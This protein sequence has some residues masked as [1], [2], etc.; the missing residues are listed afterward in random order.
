MAKTLLQLMGGSACKQDAVV[1]GLTIDSRGVREG[2][3]F[4]AVPGAKLDGRAYIGEALRKGAAAILTVPGGADDVAERNGQPIIEH[5]NPRKLYAEMAAKFYGQQPDVQVAVTGTNGKTSVADFTRQIWQAIGSEAASYGTLGV[6]S[7][8]LTVEGGLTTPDPMALHSTLANL[9][10]AGIDHVAVEASSHGLDQCRLDGMK[11]RAAA[12]TNLTRDHLDYHGT[13]QAYFQA[14]ARLFIDLVDSESGCVVLNVDDPWGQILDDIAV[15]LR[16]NRISYG[17][18]KTAALRLVS[19]KLTPAGQDVEITYDGAEIAFHIPLLGEFQAFNVLAAMG[20]AIA[21]GG[22]IDDVV[23]AIPKL[24]GVPGRME[25]MGISNGIAVYV[26]YAHTPDG[27]RTVLNAA[28]AHAS[29]KLHVV[30]GCGGDRDQGKR[31]EMGE[32]A[33]KLAD[34]IYVTDD[35]PRTEDAAVIR[36][37]IIESCPDALEIADRR[38]AIE[39]AIEAAQAGDIIIVAGKGHETGQSIGNQVIEYSDIE[40]VVDLLSLG[41]SAGTDPQLQPKGR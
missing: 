10:S 12:F 29:R 38:S 39:A 11:I 16:V 1:S 17:R 34:Y 25:L 7:S 31:P 36:S 24:V 37:Q 35:N 40:T 41:T 4:V 13:E 2:D 18:S 5:S 32:I 23:N 20:L 8:A 21:T 28:R 30:F 26:D 27:L 9:K 6:R 14:K 3:L 19:T 22:N 33:A 15:G